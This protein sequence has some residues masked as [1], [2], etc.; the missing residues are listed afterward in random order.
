[1]DINLK[2]PDIEFLRTVKDINENPESYPKTVE[3]D[4]AVPA[5]K[6]VIESGSPLSKGEIEYR[7]DDGNRILENDLIR[8]HDAPYDQERQVYGSKGIE[9]TAAGREA[10]ADIDDRT[11]DAIGQSSGGS[12]SENELKRIR[13]RL[14]ELEGSSVSGDVDGQ[15]LAEL[16]E[17]VERLDRTVASIGE[18]VES[19]A[20]RLGRVEQS[21]WGGVSDENVEDM[22]LLLRRG[23]AMFYAFN[24]LLSLDI[25]EIVENDGIDPERIEVVQ[26][27]IFTELASASSGGQS[28]SGVGGEQTNSGQSVRPSGNE[29]VDASEDSDLDRLRPD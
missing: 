6:A 2:L 27:Q 16:T 5:T 11:L 18:E 10:L 1:M 9:L 12:I 7:A 8:L 17:S 24:N 4:A 20:K 19:M 3:H 21:D 28:P 14:D 29:T 26:E 22:L 15:Q 25:D 23:A 13:N